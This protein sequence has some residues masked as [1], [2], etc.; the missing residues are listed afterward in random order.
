MPRQGFLV[1]AV[2]LLAAVPARAPQPG[3]C[4]RIWAV[5]SD[6]AVSNMSQNHTRL[7]R[8]VRVDCNDIQLFADE[9]EIF[10]DAD[11]VRASGNVLFI[12]STNRISADRMEF[13]TRTKTGTF[14]N[15]SGIAS[16]EGRSGVEQSL[17]GTQEPDAFFYG[18]TIEK[19][20][21]KTYRIRN[22]GFTTC[23]QPTPRW[24]FV[25]NDVTLTLEKHAFIK[26]AV[27]K[28]KDVPVFYLPAMYYPI[29]KE[30]RAT[31][32]LM[33]IY[34]RSTIKGQT[35]D[36]AF[37]WAINRSQDATFYHSW[38][39]KTGQSIAGEYRY[40]QSP[41]SSGNLRTVYVNEHDATYD[42][43]DG[44]QQVVAG[45]DNYTVNGQLVQQLPGNV[46]L[47]GRAAYFSS[48]IGQQR[49]QQDI[50]A[51]TNRNRI[52]NI[53]ASKSWRGD[54]VSATIDRTETFTNDTQSQVFG[55]APRVLYSHAEQRLGPLPIYAGTSAEYVTLVNHSAGTAQ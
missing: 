50:L 24:E 34:G 35:L 51:A 17:F 8:Q 26:N 46:R 47:S 25:S 55:S 40:V 29:N 31:G 22:G 19:L 38:F 21:P 49:Y 13:N 37:F 39:S 14:Y 1:L 5:A 42:Q 7:L 16:M 28:V 15:A 10:S 20:G 54:T 3:G 12:S 48:L 11:R 2:L 41:T 36:N 45:I 32:F 43:P 44:S 33:P 30:D 9:A 23:V 18:E 6:D 4:T 52:F 53:N 27:L